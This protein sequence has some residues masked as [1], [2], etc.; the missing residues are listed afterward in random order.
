MT[1]HEY[2][3]TLRRHWLSI[4][5]FGVLGALVATALAMNSPT[6]YRANSSVLVTSEV[7]SSGSDLVQGSTYVQNLVASYVLL[8]TSE[9]VLRP[10]IDQLQL[11]TT[12]MALS[13]SITADSPINTVVINIH[14]NGSD[15]RQI[16]SIANAVTRSLSDAVAGLSP[17]RSDGKPAI[18][19][20]MTQSASAPRVPIAPNK[21]RWLV[22]GLLLGLAAG[23]ALALA[24]R[25][26]HS[27]IGDAQDVAR[28]TDVPVVGEIVEA[29]RG[30]TL[31]ATVLT[32][33]RGLQAE[34]LRA[35][36]ANLN[37]LGIGG[38]L[39]SFVITS[40]SPGEAKS[41][42]ATATALVLAEASH[43]VLLIDGDLRAP[44]LHKLTS[45]DNTLGLT[46][47]LIGEDSIDTAAQQWGEQG[48]HVLASGPL[49]PNPSQLLNSDAMRALIAEAEQS[50]DYV[51][52]D[53][54]PLLSVAD[55]VWL[56]HM[57]DG[58]LL[59]ARRDHTKP[60]AL[61][62]A[63]ESLSSSNTTVAGIVVSR[64]PRTG[65]K[66]YGVAGTGPRRTFRSR[67]RDRARRSRH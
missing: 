9:T 52:I 36:M 26:F 57:V 38:G 41:S 49:P 51:V 30:E 65:K 21:K 23:V 5:V 29:R 14:V 22:M 46:T 59:V 47:V 27:A 15:P 56:G 17:T 10:V 67:R 34:S 31:P 60:R 2:V 37:F 6:V 28:L 8:T 40:P 33:T 53:S 44:T 55:A 24:R 16:A 54:A 1:L 35:L 45:L 58:V 39:R 4:G 18:R 42:I 32:D 62:R 64:V 13:H 19:L 25:T 20:S 7:G 11:K 61:H 48:L 63:L 66:G 43:K 12:P 3:A 50:Y